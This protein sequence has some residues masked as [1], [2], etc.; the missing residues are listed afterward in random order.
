MKHLMRDGSYQ[1][2]LAALKKDSP[3]IATAM[4]DMADCVSAAIEILS[5]Q[6]GAEHAY[7]PNYVLPMAAELFRASKGFDPGGT[8]PP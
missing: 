8:P 2:V 4:A 6:L 7:N 1:I 5:N 3:H